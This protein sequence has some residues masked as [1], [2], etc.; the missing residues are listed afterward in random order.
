MIIGVIGKKRSGKDTIADFL[1]RKYQFQQGS[2]AK[3]IKEC[4]KLIFDWTDEHVYGSLKEVVDPRWGISPRQAMQHFGTDWAQVE[5]CKSFPAFSKKTGRSL[6]VKRLLADYLKD[7]MKNDIVISDARFPH[8]KK[9]IEDFAKKNK[10]KCYF[11]R[12]ERDQ[13]KKLNEKDNHAS[14]K[15]ME[16][17][18]QDI[19]IKNNGTLEE[20]YA[21]VKD[22][23]VNVAYKKC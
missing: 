9:C 3:P 13:N 5:L 14:E 21:K 20:L 7:G 8:E 16:S 11:I 10:V 19:I 23:I 12:V 18:G 22:C 17:M 1:K 4:C 15:E 2:F 6:W